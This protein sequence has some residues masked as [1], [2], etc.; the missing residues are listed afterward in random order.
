MDKKKII[1][2]S[3]SV[4]IGVLIFGLILWFIL[5]SGGNNN[6]KLTIDNFQVTS[7]GYN[8]EI[9][10][11][12]N[13]NLLNLKYNKCDKSVYW[14]SADGSYPDKHEYV[15]Y[16]NWFVKK[17]AG[18]WIKYRLNGSVKITKFRL[19]LHNVSSETYCGFPSIV[20][21]AG[22]NDDV[23]IDNNASHPETWTTIVDN[24]NLKINKHQTGN[25]NYTIDAFIDFDKAYTFKYYIIQVNAINDGTYTQVY[26][27]IYS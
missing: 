27:D 5:K 4:S 6:N 12:T 7:S 11:A 3:V 18:Q 15:A 21:V 9:I 16:G 20:T 2:I 24:K 13:Y 25:N 23:N 19:H 10:D 1:I 14:K 26:V 22:S 8:P 17:S